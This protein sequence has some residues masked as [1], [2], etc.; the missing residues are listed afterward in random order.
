V[1]YLI[2]PKIALLRGK[3]AAVSDVQLDGG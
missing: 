3:R 1:E 2:L